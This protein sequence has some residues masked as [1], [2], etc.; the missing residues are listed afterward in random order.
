MNKPS[1]YS[2]CVVSPKKIISRVINRSPYINKVTAFFCCLYLCY[3]FYYKKTTV[4]TTGFAIFHSCFGMRTESRLKLGAFSMT[5]MTNMALRASSI[6]SL[7]SSA[8]DITWAWR[9][10]MASSL[11]IR[12]LVLHVCP[13]H[14]A[15]WLY[16]CL[17]II[18]S[19]YWLHL[20]K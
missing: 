6:C 15:P 14:P 16:F 19:V 8:L 11:S 4:F 17:Y 5:S 12:D 18:A 2:I 10:F 9:H 3:L 13:P 7:L 1:N 20:I